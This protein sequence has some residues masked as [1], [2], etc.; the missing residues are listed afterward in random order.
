ME[1]Q[2]K[3][4]SLIFTG[5]IESCLHLTPLKE[6]R[7]TDCSHTWF[8]LKVSWGRKK[9]TIAEKQYFLMAEYNRQ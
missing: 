2:K 7:S 4:Q 8:S 3:V 6:V 9:N 1:A 5:K